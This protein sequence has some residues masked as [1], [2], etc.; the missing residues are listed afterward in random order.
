MPVAQR[1]RPAARPMVHRVVLKVSIMLVWAFTLVKLWSLAHCDTTNTAAGENASVHMPR[2]RLRGTTVSADLARTPVLVTTAVSPQTAVSSSLRGSVATSFPFS[3]ETLGA[4]MEDDRVLQPEVPYSGP[5]VLSGHMR[6]EVPDPQSF[7][8]DTDAHNAVIDGIAHILDIRSDHISLE[9]SWSGSMLMMSS[10]EL[11]RH[12]DRSVD[13][14]YYV[15]L[16]PHLVVS[17][18]SLIYMVNSQVAE[19][20]SSTIQEELTAIKGQG[21][22]VKVLENKIAL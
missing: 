6:M 5:L 2:R 21:Y 11:A 8:S 16:Q 7:L 20:I 13:V 17:P 18:M 3:I 12:I 15:R 10:H 22:I 14:D 19:E 9:V 4:R 1:K